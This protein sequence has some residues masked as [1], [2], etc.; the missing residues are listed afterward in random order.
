MPPETLRKT[1]ALSSNVLRHTFATAGFNVLKSMELTNMITGHYSKYDRGV[2]TPTYVHL[3]A[4][5]H[6]QYFE[7][8]GDRLTGNDPNFVDAD[9]WV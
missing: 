1:N 7:Q 9:D 2:G 8:I 6:R 5:E 4:D 3:Q